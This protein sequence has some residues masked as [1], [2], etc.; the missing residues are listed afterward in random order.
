L[1]KEYPGDLE[2]ELCRSPTLEQKIDEA[3]I[4]YTT[5]VKENQLALW[6]ILGSQIP[7]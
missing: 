6:H 2:I 7:I 3:K 1:K 5:L 4:F